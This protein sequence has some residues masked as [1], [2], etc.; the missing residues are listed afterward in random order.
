MSSPLNFKQYVVLPHH[1]EI[2]L[3]W[4]QI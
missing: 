2:V 4:L 3:W 1:I